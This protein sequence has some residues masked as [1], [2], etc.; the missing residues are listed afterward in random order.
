MSASISVW[1]RMKI[2]EGATESARKADRGFAG[3]MRPS[4]RGT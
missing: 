1:L 4:R 2:A 3:L